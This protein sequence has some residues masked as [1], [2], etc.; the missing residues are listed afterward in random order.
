MNRFRH[1]ART[2]R[3]FFEQVYET[4]ARIPRGRVVTYGQIALLL[5]RPNGARTVG[6]AMQS[7]PADRDLPC[8]RVVRAS[9]ELAPDHVFGGAGVQRKLLEAEGVAF[10]GDGRIDLDAHLWEVAPTA[11]GHLVT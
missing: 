10:L 3:S 7:A 2:P 5:G 8:H 11:V 6:W 1:A 4:V 9:G